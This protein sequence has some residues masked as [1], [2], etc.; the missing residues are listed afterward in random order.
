M[1]IEWNEEA[2]HHLLMVMLSQVCSNGAES[3]KNKK[4]VA[5]AEV[6]ET[7]NLLGYAV[8]KDAVNQRYLKH[9]LIKFNKEIKDAK[10]K[11]AEDEAK[12]SEATAGAQNPTKTASEADTEAAGA[13]TT[14]DATNDDSTAAATTAVHTPPSPTPSSRP[15]PTKRL[16]YTVIDSDDE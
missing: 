13:G 10:E 4:K 15:R 11:K 8:S 14:K 1:P 16:K 3:D 9:I 6:A 12:A 7:M 5:W 2:N